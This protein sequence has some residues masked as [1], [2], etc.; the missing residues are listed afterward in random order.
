MQVL[1]KR[2]AWKIHG[3][4]EV[5]NDLDHVDWGWFDVCNPF[6]NVMLADLMILLWG[7]W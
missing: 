3:F 2:I 1:R 4:A 7:L 5:I 6:C